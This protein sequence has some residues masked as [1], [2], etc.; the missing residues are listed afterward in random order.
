MNERIQ[1]IADL[2][3]DG[4]GFIDVGTDHGYL[5]VALAERGYPGTILASDIGEEP[6]DAARRTAAQAGCTDRIRFLLC[7]GLALCPPDAVDTIVI[8]GL[9]GDTI[10]KILDEAEWCMDQRYTLI[11]QPMTKA[12]VVRYWLVYNEFEIRCEELVDDA[13]T[14]YQILVAVF[15]GETKLT[16][17]E[18]FAG[19]AALAKDRELYGRQLALLC[20]RFEQAIRGMERGESRNSP[21]DR[22]YREILCHLREMMREQT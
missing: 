11:L 13:G 17:A 2:I 21:R 8:A 9:G 20:A 15:G 4:K 18:L 14:L 16:D 6:L 3:P 12:E 1:A 5:P 10:V 22:L 19:K 7:D